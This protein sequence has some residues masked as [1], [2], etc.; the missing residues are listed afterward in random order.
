VR[1]LPY[2]D[3]ALL[4]EVD[5]LAGVLAL[6][7]ALSRE[8]IEG[9]IDIVPAARTVL[10]RFEAGSDLA[11]IRAG[12]DRLTVAP[13]DLESVDTEIE[14]PVVYDGKDL[15]SVA[16][17]LELTP[18]ALIRAHTDAVWTVAFCGFAPGF[19]YLTGTDERLASVPRRSSPRTRIPAGSVALAGGF[20]AVYPGASPGGWQLLGRTELR[21]FDVE[22]DPPARLQPGV[23]VRFVDRDS[24][25]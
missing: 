20:S 25:S 12:L 17:M 15:A 4:L 5:D 3:R 8:P 18:A 19:A 6:D 16:R 2:G 11:T 23:R 14:I 24:D 22:Q 13:I 7:A 10:I 21:T 9:V 1:V